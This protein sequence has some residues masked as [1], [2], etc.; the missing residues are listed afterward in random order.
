MI[1]R[2][3]WL[4]RR[5]DCPLWLCYHGADGVVFVGSGIV[6]LAV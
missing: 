2:Y 4:A 1:S 5:K 3:T 6:S